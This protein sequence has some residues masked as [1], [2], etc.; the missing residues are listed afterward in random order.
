MVLK[1]AQL[2]RRKAPATK[3]P[4]KCPNHEIWIIQPS[5]KQVKTPSE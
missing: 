5:T 4:I 2:K 1:L 3:S